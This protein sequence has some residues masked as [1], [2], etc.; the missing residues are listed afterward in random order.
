MWHLVRS[1]CTICSSF[2][3]SVPSGDMPNREMFHLGVFPVE[4]FI[5]LSF[6]LSLH[7]VLGKELS[8]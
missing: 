8:S 4:F 5:Q 6:N 3:P 2:N 7:S 1:S